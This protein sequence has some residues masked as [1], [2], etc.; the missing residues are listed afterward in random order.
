MNAKETCK[1]SND[2]LCCGCKLEDLNFESTEELIPLQGVIGQDR[3]SRALDFGLSMRKR[4]YNIYV[5]GNWGSGRNSYV[6][7]ITE[8]KAIKEDAPKDWI[9]VNNFKNAHNP[10]AISVETGT[11]KEFI[12]QI[13]KIIN[14]LRKEIENVFTSKD[15]ENA[16]SGLVQ[17]YN[18]NNQNIIN[19]LND[20]G[21]EYGFRFSQT[22][23]GLVSIPL[24][25][26]EPMSEEE[27]RAISDEEYE[28][29]RGNSNKLSI[30]TVDLFNKLRF[31]EDELRRKIKNLEERM[32]RRV[33]S[34]HFM[35][36]REKYKDNSEV[37]DYIDALIED[38]VEHVEQFRGD[39]EQE[40]QANPL[41]M[42]QM[43]DTESFF[44][45]YRMNLFIDNSEVDHAPIVFASNP[46][47]YNLLGSIEYRNELGVMKTDF[48]QI[49]PGLLHEANG[50]YLIILA[51]DIL[52]I[53]Y[54]WKGLKRALLDQEISIESIGSQT[55]SIVSTTLKPQPIPLDV[56]I[57][58]IGD[59]YT[60]H[61]LYNYDEEFRKL[62]KVMADFD[63]EMERNK[64]NISKMS[65][66]IAKHCEKD[67][68]KHFDKKAVAKII[69]YSSRLADD[70]DKLSA[71]LN[72][73]VDVLYE[74]DR[75][76][77]IYNS[78]LVRPDHVVKALEEIQYRS[79]KYEEKVFEMFEDGTYLID[80]AGYKV[81][82]INGLAVTGSGQYR[83]GKPSKITVSTY[84]GRAGVVNIEREARQSGSH[85]DKGVMILTG[86][87]GDR[88]AKDKPLAMTAG[89]V[90]EQSYS[91]IDGDS[92][93]STELYAILSSLS[94]VPINQS[95]A[96]T[97][98]VNQRGEI[99]PIGGV[100]E[101]IEGFYKVC[102]LKGL[103]GEQ[104][105]MIP[106]Q[107][108]RNLMLCGEVREA[109]EKGMFSIY[110]IEHIEQGIEILTGVKAGVANKNG[111]YPRGSV[112]Y[113]VDKRLKELA[114]SSEPP[115][116]KE[117]AQDKEAPKKDEE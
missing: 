69:E 72:K 44:N 39:Q 76:A 42:F 22:E 9:Y 95:I 47:Y 67:N 27:Y 60:Y 81:G 65:R 26:G 61:M 40:Q 25:D 111:N 18:V 56:K 45:R 103:N 104:G 21:A 31:E 91:I 79:N 64:E 92:A 6:R 12:K 17:E 20:I 52:T 108:V 83:F 10:L 1:L 50:G 51:K 63:V 106:H 109:V 59:A 28:T 2:Q 85:H 4:G 77:E 89:I 54:A 37:K 78:R 94:G 57:I 73:L 33:V 34:F 110:A 49:K 96:V 97:G 68:L 41:A 8:E 5:S 3:A 15:Y 70:Q 16:K 55:G 80:V 53:P 86:F 74:A 84:K 19:E 113:K 100:N 30:E 29:L 90:F 82:E 101:K 93:S 117:E 66:F 112:F 107:N 32:G 114:K 43:K 71:H 48:T 46:T 23:K 88:F 62:F 24:K 14:F 105:V 13:E 7:L 38:I 36:L 87:L 116:K 75:W 102:K 58:V 11:A 98:S 115:K 35:N 99:Q